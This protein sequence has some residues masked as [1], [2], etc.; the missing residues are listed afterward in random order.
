MT[1]HTDLI[2]RLRDSAATGLDSE[3]ADQAANALEAQAREIAEL[4]AQEAELCTLHGLAEAE[5][6]RLRAELE[7]TANNRDM[8]KSQCERQADELRKLR[9][10]DAESNH[11]H[12]CTAC[13]FAYTPTIAGGEDCPQCGW[14]GR[15]TY[16]GNAIESVLQK[17]QP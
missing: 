13:A 10:T 14:D 11:S 12:R 6:K 7:R 17:A 16:A 8:W 15:G 9:S 4:K 3:A 5:C 1:Q 2:E